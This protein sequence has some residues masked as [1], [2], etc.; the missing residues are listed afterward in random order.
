MEKV[1][2]I[3]T[4]ISDV[5]E[6]GS[7]Y[8]TYYQLTKAD[9][10][11]LYGDEYWTSETNEACGFFMGIEFDVEQGVPGVAECGNTAGWSNEELNDEWLPALYKFIEEN[12]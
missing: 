12:A 10:D 8:D 5:Y 4:S 3:T 11:D 7:N 1:T 2:A 6:Y 9:C